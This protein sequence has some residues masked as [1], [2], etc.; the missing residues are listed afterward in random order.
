MKAGTF[1]MLIDR[2][3]ARLRHA[4]WVS[5]GAC[6]KMATELYIINMPWVRLF[7]AQL[8][9]GASMTGPQPMFMALLKVWLWDRGVVSLHHQLH[10][11]CDYTSVYGRRLARTAMAS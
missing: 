10:R 2:S 3:T 4:R 9:S 6:D 1:Q 11:C 8:R 7:G 5:S